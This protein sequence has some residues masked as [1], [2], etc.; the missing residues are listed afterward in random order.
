MCVVKLFFLDL[1]FTQKKRGKRS[2]N[3]RTKGLIADDNYTEVMIT[4]CVSL[5]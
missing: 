1:Q 5:L 2:I 3:N 4:L